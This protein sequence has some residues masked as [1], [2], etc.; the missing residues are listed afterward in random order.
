M[1]VKATR[2]GLV[3]QKTASGYVI[4]RVVP[5]VA[6]PSERALGR[7][8]RVSNPLTGKSCVAIVLEVG[9]FNTTD[10]R[11]V[12]HGERPLAESGVSISGEGTNKAGI[13]LGEKVWALLGMKDNTPV[14]WEFLG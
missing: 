7:A 10:D 4:D 3:G 13:D 8:V 2:E 5:F 6:L 14:I 9:P 11:Y 12:F 1:L